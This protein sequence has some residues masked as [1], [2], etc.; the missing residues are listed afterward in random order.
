MNARTGS[1]A[2]RGA[3]FSNLPTLPNLGRVSAG[4]LEEA[5]IHSVGELEELGSVAAFQAVQRMGR[6]PS[7]L[8]LYALEAGLMGLR[9]DLLPEAVK[10]SLRQRAGME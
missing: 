4:W 2:G 5:G 9:W 1:K 10:S 8:L 6:N 7:L 3:Q